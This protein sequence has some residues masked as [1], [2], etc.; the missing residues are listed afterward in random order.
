MVKNSWLVPRQCSE[1]LEWRARRAIGKLVRFGVLLLILHFSFSIFNFSFALD[2]PRFYGEEVVVTATRLPQL[3]SKS[4]W[5]TSIISAEELK[6]FKTVGEVLRVLPGVDSQ[7]FGSYGSLN[8]IRLRGSNASQVLIL[9]D[10][11]RIN[12]P[13]LGMFDLGDLL[14]DNIERIEVVKAPLSAVYGSD[15]IAGVVNIISKDTKKSSTGLYISSGTNAT[16]QYKVSLAGE[17][18]L[19]VADQLRSQGFRTNSDYLANSLYGKVNFNLP[20]AECLIDY[21]YYDAVKGVPGVPTLEAVPTSAS[22]P[23]DRQKDNNNFISLCLKNDNSQVRVFQNNLDQKL[24]PYTW[25]ATQTTTK[26]TGIEW[27]QRRPFNYGE[28]LYGLEAREDTGKSTMAGEHLV[29]NLAAFVQ[30]EFKIGDQ[31]SFAVTV[32]GDK[33][34]T[35]GISIN[36]RLGWACQAT[37]DLIVRA[38]AGTAFRAPTLNE[39]YWNDGWMFGDTNLKPERSVAYEIGLEKKFAENTTA[40]LNYYV[41]N[42]TDMILWDW[43]SSTTETRAKNVGE[44]YSQGVEFELERKLGDNGRGFI[45]YTYQKAVDNKDFDPLA[46]GKTIRYTPQSKYNLGLILGESSLLVKHVGQRYGD[47]YNTVSLPAYTIVDLRIAKKINL[48]DL[49]FKAENLFDAVYSEAVGTYFDPN[50]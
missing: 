24:D 22:S 14:A 4:P 26:Q 50:T 6:N 33:H 3:A 13:T 39:L 38:S 28:L 31:N 32:R 37:E 42:I 46:V 18:Y 40:K 41:S 19:V 23:N 8:S 29:S 5:N 9:V 20:I 10:G 44:V 25:G 12:S 11:K 16:N 1:W 49:E 43:Q 47:Q 7:S 30:D 17:N 35:A 21:N 2:I 15:A 34:S 45:N 48:V 36:P 27:Q